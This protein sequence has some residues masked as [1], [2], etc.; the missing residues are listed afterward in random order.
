MSLA[1]GAG[2]NPVSAPTT[3][4]DVA[5]AA[6]PK[7]MAKRFSAIPRRVLFGRR[8]QEINS[9]C[10]P[11]STRYCGRPA[12]RVGDGGFGHVDAEV[13]IHRRDDLWHRHQVFLGI[14]AEPV[15][16]A[17]GLPRATCWSVGAVRPTVW[18]IATLNRGCC[19][20]CFWPLFFRQIEVGFALSGCAFFPA[21]KAPSALRRQ[22]A[23]GVE[24]CIQSV[25]NGQNFMNLFHP[26]MPIAI[27]F[28][29]FT[30]VSECD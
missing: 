18:G 16:G 17:N 20:L 5:K 25:L 9:G 7:R 15:C 28:A 12:G 10:G 11:A 29:L 8:I 26:E 21:H 3:S 14:F 1:R 13:V 19:S 27:E 6:K 22:F 24:R 30:S 23:H 2:V 4:A